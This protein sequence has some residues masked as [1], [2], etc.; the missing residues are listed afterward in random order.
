M[1]RHDLRRGCG[2]R[3]RC[4]RGTA[5]RAVTHRADCTAGLCV[6]RPNAGLQLE[7]ASWLHARC[8]RGPACRACDADCAQCHRRRLRAHLRSCRLWRRGCAPAHADLCRAASARAHGLGRA[9]LRRSR[10]RVCSR[11][12]L[13]IAATAHCAAGLAAPRLRSSE[14]RSR[15]RCRRGRCDGERLRGAARLSADADAPCLCRA[16]QAAAHARLHAK[17]ACVC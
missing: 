15:R 4:R 17:E 14:G 10:A 16:V 5:A 2:G 12:C 7:P 3:L 13:G 6:R 11:L 8:W 9:L 1:C